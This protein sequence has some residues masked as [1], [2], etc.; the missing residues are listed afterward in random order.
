MLSPSGGAGLMASAAASNFVAVLSHGLLH[1][2]VVHCD[3]GEAA[4]SP[5]AAWYTLRWQKIR[6]MGW[7]HRKM[8][9]MGIFSTPFEQRLIFF[10]NENSIFLIRFFSR[11]RS[12]KCA[13]R[14]IGAS[15]NIKK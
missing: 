3:R 8:H 15:A 12:A 1:G 14:E 2:V 10:T 13:V 6:F 5:R 7:L 11:I 9:Q 4:T